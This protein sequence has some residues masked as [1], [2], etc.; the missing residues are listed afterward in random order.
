MKK[1]TNSGIGEF[2]SLFDLLQAFPDETSC[3]NY[4]EKKLWPDGEPVSLYDPTSKVYRRGDG[5]YRCKNTGKNFNIR[6][7]TI[8][9]GSKVELRKWFIAIFEITT[10]SKGIFSVKLAND[11]GVTQKTAWYMN[12]RIREAFNIALEEKLDGEVELDETFVGGKNKNRHKNK[13]VRH[14]QGRS[15]KDKTPVLGMLQRGGKVVCRVVKSTSKKHLT[16]PI[17]RTVKR[18]AKLFTDEWC[19]YDT[20]GKIYERK[21]VDHGKGQYVCGDAYTNTIE[22]FWSG[23]K[24]GIIGIYHKVSRKHLCRYVNEFVFRYNTKKIS[25]VE[26]FNLLLCNINYRTTYQD[27][28]K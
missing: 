26:R 27:L 11:I 7:G 12:H 20:V 6:I 18:T 16:A 22:G 4:L 8:F 9:E 1:T 25:S 15:F 23:L 3:I 24:R 14:S 19:G 10:S 28:I 17:L 13:K 21:I 5:M 2:K